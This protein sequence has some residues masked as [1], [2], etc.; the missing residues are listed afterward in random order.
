MKWQNYEIIG[1]VIKNDILKL[2]YYNEL[3]TYT[4][5]NNN[6]STIL[7]KIL[8]K[9]KKLRDLKIFMINVCLNILFNF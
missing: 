6:N 4:H 3:N 7:S 8:M 1:E 2:K 5:D 9:Y